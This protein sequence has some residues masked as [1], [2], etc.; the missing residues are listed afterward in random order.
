M[1]RAVGWTI[2]IV[3][4]VFVI[5]IGAVLKRHVKTSSDFFLAGSN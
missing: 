4:F 5:G 1:L 3:Y 2:M